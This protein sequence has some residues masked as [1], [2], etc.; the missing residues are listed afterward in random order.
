MKRTRPGRKR[1]PAFSVRAAKAWKSPSHLA[2]R[3]FGDCSTALLPG[4][5]LMAESI[6]KEPHRHLVIY[7]FRHITASKV[8]PDC[9]IQGAATQ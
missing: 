4:C 9:A 6:G 8:L 2:R 5:D 1:K 7:N 3:P